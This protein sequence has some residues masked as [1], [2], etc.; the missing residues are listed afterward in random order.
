MVPE[1]DNAIFTQKPGDIGVVKSQFGYHVVQV[2]ERQQAH[3]QALGEVIDSIKA[4]LSRQMISQAEENFAKQLAAEAAKKDCRPRLPRTTLTWLPRNRSRPT[5]PSPPCRMAHRSSANPSQP[6]RVTHPQYAPTGEGFAIFQVAGI[7]KAHAPTFADWKSHVLDD[8]RDEQLPGLL[9]Q[10][11]KELADKAKASGDLNKAAKEMGAA[12]K[13][14][15]TV[16]ET[17]RFRIWAQVQSVAPQ[18]F[19]LKVGDISAPI[20]AG[21]TGVV[22][23][24]LAKTEPT[25]DDIKK[26]FDQTRDQILQ[27]RR[28]EAFQLFV[29]NLTNDYKKNKRIVVNS[30]ATPRN[31]RV[32]SREPQRIRGPHLQSAGLFACHCRPRQP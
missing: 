32:K 10:K 3:T 12:I 1:F 29:A 4:T 31:R 24:L 19:D 8:Y 26:N 11:T 6:S 23:K 22:A 5:A 15:D 13:T 7:T 25:D 9:N 17:A 2:E 30:K 28:G 14:S 20:N 27:Q 21:R 18:L 16:G